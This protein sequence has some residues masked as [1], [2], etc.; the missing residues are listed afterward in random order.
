M[1]RETME[2]QLSDTRGNI[3]IPEK[4]E[5]LVRIFVL[6]IGLMLLS[7]DIDTWFVGLREDNNAL[8]SQF[9]RNHIYYGLG[10]TK[11]FHTYGTAQTPPLKPKRY[12]NNPPLLSVWAAIAMVIFGDHEWVGRSVSIATTLGS[13]WILM[14]IISRLQSPTLGL[15][16]GLFYLILPMTAY[17]GRIV[18]YT[19]A[20]Q[21]FSLLML[22]G[23][24]QWAGFYGNGYRRNAGVPYYILGVVLGIGTGWAAVIMAGLI[25]LWHICRTFRDRSQARFLLWLTAIPAISLA[26][27]TIHILYSGG[28]FSNLFLSRTLGA[29]LKEPILW[30]G[31]AFANRSYLVGNFSKLGIGAAVVYPLIITGVIRYARENS[32]PRQIVRNGA[33]VIPILLTLLQGLIWVIVF[34]Q[35][36]GAHEYWQYFLTPFFATAMASVILTVFVLLSEKM[37]RFAAGVTILLMFLPLPFF[38]GST[39]ELYHYRWSSENTFEIIPVFKKLDQIFPPRTAVM[40]SEDYRHSSI[41]IPQLDYYA[42]RPLIYSRDIGEIETNHQGCAAYVLEAKDDPNAYQ[43]AEKLKEKYK[44]VYAEQGYMIFLLNPH[45]ADERVLPK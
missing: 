25:W 35:Q 23:Y 6:A 15:L 42:N 14:V 24:L 44:L 43:F 30:G 17:F 39:E 21:F 41:S 29:G 13:A 26:A 40:V 16:T 8:Y 45:P 18:E 22:H 7:R 36:S 37:P 3:A 33:S 27:V 31:W 32:A 34:R 38:I 12:L 4:V 10:Y 11:L 9:A 20:T 19:S 28:S 2:T 1:S 5:F